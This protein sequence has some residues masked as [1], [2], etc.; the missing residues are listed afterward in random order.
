MVSLKKLTRGLDL[1]LHLFHDIVSGIN[2]AIEGLSSHTVGVLTRIKVSMAHM[3][4]FR[5]MVSGHHSAIAT[6][7]IMK[8]VYSLTGT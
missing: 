3:A 2:P 6:V 8:V 4:R 7:D 1:V 5:M